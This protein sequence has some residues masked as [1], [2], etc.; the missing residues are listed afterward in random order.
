M[1]VNRILLILCLLGSLVATGQDNGIYVLDTD[2]L[3]LGK[4]EGGSVYT[5][6]DRIGFNYAGNIIYSGS[7]RQ[8]ENILM[9]V[10]MKDAW[11]KKAGI[12][13]EA[14]GKDVRYI[15]RKGEMFLGDYPIDT[16][17][18]RLLRIGEKDEDGWKVYHGITDEPLGT[19]AGNEI[20]SVELV[21]AA[22]LFIT[23]FDLDREV[24]EY[25]EAHSIPNTGTEGAAIYPVLDPFGPMRWEWDGR[26]LR[27][28]MDLSGAE[29]SFDG[30]TI[31]SRMAGLES[32]WTY[33]NGMLKPAWNNDP[34]FRY[35]WKENT[36]RPFWD[37]NPDKMWVLEDGIMRPMWNTDPALQWEI[38]GDMP[39]PLIALVVL[40]F[41]R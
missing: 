14:N 13:Y 11:S 12:V 1:Q 8:Q 22:F 24:I 35:E 15:F 31:Q 3:L 16:E 6:P 40:G 25:I 34:Q 37:S 4:M 32:S 29:W 2:T 33:S 18:E 5:A 21:M 19:I 9:M 26:V 39:L 23:A 30:Q 17:L 38:A 7:A 41:I 20:S 28:S 36:L 27:R 10:R